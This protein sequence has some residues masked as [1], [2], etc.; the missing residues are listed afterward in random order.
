LN[1]RAPSLFIQDPTGFLLVSLNVITG[2]QWSWR[3]SS[4]PPNNPAGCASK[5]VQDR[6]PWRTFGFCI[7]PGV[8]WTPP[9][10][11]A[12][13]AFSRGAPGRFCFVGGPTPHIWSTCLVFF[14]PC[15]FFHLFLFLWQFHFL[16][17]P[18]PF[19]A[20]SPRSLGAVPCD[21]KTPYFFLPHAFFLTYPLRS[22]P[23]Q[24][25]DILFCETFFPQQ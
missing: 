23:S 6:L 13:L 15:Y 20:S 24:K 1:R 17:L 7:P 19:A 3:C 22:F 9:L 10:G 2:R 12:L 11:G 4:C 25:A 5:L 8:I 14:G 21:P 18:F 16:F